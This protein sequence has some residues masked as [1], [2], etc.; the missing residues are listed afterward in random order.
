MLA[1]GLALLYLLLPF[2]ATNAHFS[3]VEL[4]SKVKFHKDNPAKIQH[5]KVC[6]LNFEGYPV[7]NSHMVQCEE[8]EEKE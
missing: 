3:G 6:L 2:R 4:F 1:L 5:V 8:L 7:N